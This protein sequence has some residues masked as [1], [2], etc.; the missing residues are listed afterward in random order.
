MQYQSIEN[1]LMGK[2]ILGK[3]SKHKLEFVDYQLKTFADFTNI[4]QAMTKS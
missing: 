1:L 4:W 2:S 3:P